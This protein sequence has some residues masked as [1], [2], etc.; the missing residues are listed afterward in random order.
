[1]YRDYR[2]HVIS[3]IMNRKPLIEEKFNDYFYSDLNDEIN[4]TFISG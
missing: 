1:M 3:N 4:G 2:I